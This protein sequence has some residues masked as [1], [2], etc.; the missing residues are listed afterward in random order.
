M[1]RS[2]LARRKLANFSSTAN[3]NA[4]MYLLDFDPAAGQ[5]GGGRA[6]ALRK[7]ALRKQK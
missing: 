1:G 2:Y 7:S 5:L 6:V 4:R 3:I